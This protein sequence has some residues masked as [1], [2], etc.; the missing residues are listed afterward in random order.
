MATSA[1]TKRT[2]NRSGCSAGWWVRRQVQHPR[3]WPPYTVRYLT[4]T[5]G[6]Y[7][8]TIAGW[9]SIHSSYHSIW[10][11]KFKIGPYALALRDSSSSASP[12]SRPTRHT[13]D[14]DRAPRPINKS[15]AEHAVCGIVIH[16]HAVGSGSCRSYEDRST[17]VAG[18]G[19]PPAPVC[20]NNKRFV[21]VGRVVS[22]LTGPEFGVRS[23]PRHRPGVVDGDVQELPAGTPFASPPGTVIDDTIPNVSNAA[24]PLIS[25]GMNSLGLAR[26]AQTRDIWLL[27]ECAV[28][29]PP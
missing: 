15:S 28:V 13:A 3:L 24:N 10:S 8:R 26:P 12:A 27:L 14:Q 11:R 9:C 23:M 1:P 21:H 16:A 25:T 6:C 18:G 7:R 4:S 22:L 17:G 29:A 20:P 19:F 2:Q 5:S